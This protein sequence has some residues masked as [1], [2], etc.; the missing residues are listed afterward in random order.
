MRFRILVWLI[1]LCA[2]LAPP[3]IAP[4]AAM[5]SSSHAMMSDCPDH[6][7]PPAPCPD[8]D[9]AKHAAGLC[10]PFMALTV[11]V[12]PLVAA[13]ADGHRFAGHAAPVTRDLAGLSPHKDPPPPRV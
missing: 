10:C 2:F 6:A 12:L 9:S 8:K 3:A 1:A 11:A 5:Q 7:P 13:S 4:T